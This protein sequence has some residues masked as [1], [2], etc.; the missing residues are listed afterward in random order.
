L[1]GRVLRNQ[2]LPGATSSAHSKRFAQ[3]ACEERNHEKGPRTFSTE[4]FLAILQQ[5]RKQ[6]LGQNGNSVIEY[7]MH[8]L[9]QDGRDAA[10]EQEEFFGTGWPGIDKGKL[11]SLPSFSQIKEGPVGCAQQALA[12]Q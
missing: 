6:R 1:T 2:S 4:D 5:F 10:E 7:Q 3:P 9:T 11:I 8:I 12:N